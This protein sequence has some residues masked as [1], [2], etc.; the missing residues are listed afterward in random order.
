MQVIRVGDRFASRGADFQLHE[1]LD[2]PHGS[3]GEKPFVSRER[4]S[5]LIQQAAAPG[6][7]WVSGVL[8]DS[9]RRNSP[10]VFDDLGERRFKN[11][12]D[13]TKP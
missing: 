4:L 8:F 10:F 2:I 7:V 12:S 6:T 5:T 9:I 3:S 13:V 11:M 1:R